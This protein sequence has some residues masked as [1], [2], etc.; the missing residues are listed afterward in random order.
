M[1]IK[2]CTYPGTC[3]VQILLNYTDLLQQESTSFGWPS[4]QNHKS[5]TGAV[6]RRIQEYMCKRMCKRIQVPR[7]LW[8]VCGTWYVVRGT[9]YVVPVCTW[10]S[11]S[12]SVVLL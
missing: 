10:Y 1:C 2:V 8:Y 4:G 3:H 5:I 11:H 12:H 7:C 6:Y 9:W